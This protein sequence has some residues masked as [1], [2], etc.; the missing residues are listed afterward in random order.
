MY[1]RID[2]T[3]NGTWIEE[4]RIL[5]WAVLD[6]PDYYTWSDSIRRINSDFYGFHLNSLHYLLWR[7]FTERI[8]RDYSANGLYHH[9]LEPP[10]SCSTSS[11]S[12]HF[13]HSMPAKCV[14]YYVLHAIPIVGGES[15]VWITGYNYCGISGCCFFHIKYCWDIA[16]NQ[17]RVCEWQTGTI[18]PLCNMLWSD[19]QIPDLL[20]EFYDI[21]L[22]YRSGCQVYPCP[23]Y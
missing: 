21:R 4:Y 18:G 5:Y 1:R 9:C 16:T 15:D 3:C 19:I 12:G 22:V 11:S 7:Q 10:P 20:R 8:F 13:V 2:D 14:E 17:P 6:C 23:N